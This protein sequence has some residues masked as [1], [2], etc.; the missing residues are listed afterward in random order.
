[1]FLHILLFLACS[2]FEEVD[3]IGFQRDTKLSVP[4]Q[5]HSTKKVFVVD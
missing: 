1:M 4:L 3:Y 2:K 5:I